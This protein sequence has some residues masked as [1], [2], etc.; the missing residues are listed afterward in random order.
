MVGIAAADRDRRG[1]WLRGNHAGTTSASLPLDC[2]MMTAQA[3][4]A[5]LSRA[6]RVSRRKGFDRP[7]RRS[8][9]DSNVFTV[10]SLTGSTSITGASGTLIS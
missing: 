1:A 6:P 10:A 7:G 2:P 9:N 3:D 8:T 5:V 4:V